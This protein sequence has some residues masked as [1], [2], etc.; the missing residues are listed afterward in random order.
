MSGKRNCAFMTSV[1]VG[2]HVFG[3][4]LI[5][6]WAERKGCFMSDPC[7][8]YVNFHFTLEHIII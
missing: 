7:I 1:C 5:L 8:A 3:A 6:L 2:G 4:F